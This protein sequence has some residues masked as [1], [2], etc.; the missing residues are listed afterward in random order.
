MSHFRQAQTHRDTYEG[1]VT[2]VSS[3][4]I[5]NAVSTYHAVA[6]EKATQHT[7]YGLLSSKITLVFMGY[8]I[9][10]KSAFPRLGCGWLIKTCIQMLIL[11]RN[12]L[13]L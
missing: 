6:L 7:L 9:G 2:K 12:I 10:A 13:L 11:D 1:S 4:C 3:S 5:V 8:K